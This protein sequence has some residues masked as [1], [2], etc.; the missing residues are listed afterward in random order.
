M[1]IRDGTPTDLDKLQ[2]GGGRS[3]GDNTV[4]LCKWTER[5][6]NEEKRRIG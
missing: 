4:L 2:G 5:A 1:A 3:E 6:A